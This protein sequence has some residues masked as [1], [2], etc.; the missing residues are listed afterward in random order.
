MSNEDHLSNEVSL[1]ATLSKEGLSGSV[2]LRTLAAFDRFFGSLI[3]IP[4]SKLEAI[5]KRTRARDEQEIALIASE[6]SAALNA[7]QKNEKLEA[8][9]AENF[10][11]KNTR[12]MTNKMKVAHKAISLIKDSEFS[13]EEISERIEMDDDWL[14]HLEEY[15]EKAS[16]ERM[17]NLWARVLAG[18]IRKPQSFS[19]TTLRFLS[20]LDQK[21]ATLFE[22]TTK[23]WMNWRGD[24]FIFKPEMEIM[25]N[26]TLLDLTFLEEVGLLQ[27]VNGNLNIT[28]NPGKDGFVYVYEGNFLLKFAPAKEKIEIPVIRITR[29]GREVMDILP[30]RDFSKV[31][32]SIFDRIHDSVQSAEIYLITIETNGHILSH[33]IKTLK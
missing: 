32:E 28:Y 7:I 16:S 33:C 17:Q 2:K 25:R 6:T 30:P 9:V 29:I 31:L 5:A 26:E 24:G 4:V 14:N 19:L 12:R 1:R 8:A 21:I 3:D 10:L 13:S 22:I 20:E 23:N 27:E 11:L 18:E 15:V